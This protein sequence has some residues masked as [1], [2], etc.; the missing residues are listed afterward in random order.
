M[1]L[2]FAGY[3]YYPC[4]G[5]DD[6]LGTFNSIEEARAAVLETGSDWYQVVLNSAVF[7]EGSVH[8]LRNG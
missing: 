1:Y 6:Y 7:E 3:T 2:V 5:W 8:K 4:G